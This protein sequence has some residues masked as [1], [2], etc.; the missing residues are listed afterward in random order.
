MAAPALL[1]CQPPSAAHACANPMSHPAEQLEYEATRLFEHTPTG[2]TA[3]AL[4]RGGAEAGGEDRRQR[5]PRET[6]G[7]GG[8]AVRA[9]RGAEGLP[10]TERAACDLGRGTDVMLDEVDEQRKAITA[11]LAAVEAR[12][13]S[14]QRM[15]RPATR[16]RRPTTRSTPSGPRTPT[17]CI[18]GRCSPTPRHR[19]RSGVRT[20]AMEPASRSTARGS[21]RCG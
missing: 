1:R 19:R 8:E 9:R 4:R 5:R 7:S 12:A 17:P 2:G 20:G 15:R 6:H 16:W 3:G 13:S 21:S 11:E 14:A 10:A 18:R